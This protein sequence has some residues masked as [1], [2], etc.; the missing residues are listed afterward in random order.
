MQALL[1]S[2][3]L[4]LG[5]LY[6]AKGV[7]EGVWS[8]G[9]WIAWVW[10]WSI[11]FL[12]LTQTPSFRVA[13]SDVKSIFKV[14]DKPVGVVGGKGS[15]DGTAGLEVKFGMHD[16]F[17]GFT[18]TD[19]LTLDNVFL[20]YPYTDTQDP[21]PALSGV[22]FVLP[23]ASVTAIVSV[24]GSTRSSILKALYRLYDVDSGSIYLNGSSILSLSLASLR[25]VIAVVPDISSEGRAKALSR[26]LEKDAKVILVEGALEPSSVGART[27]LWEATSLEGVDGVDQ[28][29]DSSFISEQ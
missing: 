23:V 2:A 14:L 26:A 28:Y 6:I 20:T 16:W 27:V 13:T 17:V 5:S 8:A 12:P 1:G 24:P 11:L 25:S 4:L 10:Y 21:V 9:A 29:V 19:L 3:A 22:S 7:T 18:R 15:I